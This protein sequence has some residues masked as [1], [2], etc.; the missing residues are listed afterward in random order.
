[1]VTSLYVKKL[2]V[3]YS[4]LYKIINNIHNLLLVLAR[5]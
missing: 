1:M 3:G 4:F 5:T 2:A